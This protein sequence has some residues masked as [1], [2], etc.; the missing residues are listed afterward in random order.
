MGSEH[1]RRKVDSASGAAF[2]GIS[3]GNGAWQSVPARSFRNEKNL[4]NHNGG[5]M[6]GGVAVH[7]D[8]TLGQPRRSS[9]WI[10]DLLSGQFERPSHRSALSSTAHSS[11]RGKLLA[12]SIAV[13]DTQLCS[14]VDSAN[15]F[16]FSRVECAANA[17]DSD[18]GFD[19]SFSDLGRADETRHSPVV[20]ASFLAFFASPSKAIY[21]AGRAQLFGWLVE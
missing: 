9:F 4:P 11:R 19:S 1:P 13:A 10:V 6:L 15:F 14:R 20:G 2:S 21:W 12:L 5:A 3:C 8:R 17:A 7:S 16:E 18:P